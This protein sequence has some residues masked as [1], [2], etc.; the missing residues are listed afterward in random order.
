MIDVFKTASLGDLR[1][2]WGGQSAGAAYPAPIGFDTDSDAAIVISLG[3]N[4]WSGV[5]VPSRAMGA[6]SLFGMTHGDDDRSK[7]GFVRSLSVWTS[8]PWLIVMQCEP[9]CEDSTM[10]C[11][12]GSW[13]ECSCVA[14]TGKDSYKCGQVIG[15]FQKAEIRGRQPSSTP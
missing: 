12:R 13:L 1:R 14:R 2:V 3:A 15:Q 4:T 5:Y 10:K 11:S 6:C 9:S 8:R 7:F